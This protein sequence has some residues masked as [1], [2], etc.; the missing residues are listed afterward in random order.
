MTSTK[1]ELKKAA[2]VAALA[3]LLATGSA[4]ANGAELHARIVDGDC[5]NVSTQTNE[6]YMSFQEGIWLAHK[7]PDGRWVADANGKEF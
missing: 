7:A 6:A 1:L 3:I 5:L 2:I 4:L